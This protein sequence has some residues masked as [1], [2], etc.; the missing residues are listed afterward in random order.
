[1]AGFGNTQYGKYAYPRLTTVDTC[2]TQRAEYAFS[3]LIQ[4][5]DGRVSMTDTPLFVEFRSTLI[6]RQ[7]TA[8]ARPSFSPAL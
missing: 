4:L 1:M 8:A 7:S 6:P 2:A 3:H 5:M